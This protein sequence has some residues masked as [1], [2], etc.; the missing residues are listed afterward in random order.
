MQSM[1]R[2]YVDDRATVV[3]IASRLAQSSEWVSAQL[4]GAGI[5]VSAGGARRIDV[6]E[7]WI[8]D[9]YV[10]EIP[11]VPKPGPLRTRFPQPRRSAPT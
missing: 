4:R 3:D 6:D 9:Q 2:L 5:A 8:E 1:I 7:D 10:H 11:I